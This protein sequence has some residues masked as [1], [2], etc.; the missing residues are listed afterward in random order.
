MR[1]VPNH[2]SLHTTNLVNR[3]ACLLQ[4]AGSAILL[5]PSKTMPL[6]QG[7]RRLTQDECGKQARCTSYQLL[8][9]CALGVSN[10][11]YLLDMQIMGASG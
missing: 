7:P 1:D 8:V 5:F 2:S 4:Q 6:D 11:M 9:A 3:R 10:L